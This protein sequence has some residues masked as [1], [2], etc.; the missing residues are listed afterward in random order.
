MDRKLCLVT[1]ANIPC[2]LPECWQTQSDLS[3]VIIH[4]Q[5]FTRW[6]P[7]LGHMIRADAVIS[8]L[9]PM[10]KVVVKRFVEGKDV[11]NAV[12]SYAKG[13]VICPDPSSWVGFT[14]GSGN[15]T[16]DPQIQYE[17]CYYI[18]STGHHT[19]WPPVV[20]CHEPS[21]TFTMRL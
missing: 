5:E 1:I 8:K 15:Q 7:I 20:T 21:V 16:R 4:D 12:L 10:Q 3:S 14:E 18:H 13:Y 6:R 9:H 17:P 11:W 2:H 19:N